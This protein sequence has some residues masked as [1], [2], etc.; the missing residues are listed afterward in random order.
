MRKIY[1]PSDDWDR[2]EKNFWYNILN[3][4]KIYKFGRQVSESF[5]K[6]RVHF[7]YVDL[8]SRLDR[9]KSGNSLYENSKEL[10]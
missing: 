9:Y 2:Q 3:L 1:L 6:I 4:K 7:V 8:K 5:N 10:V